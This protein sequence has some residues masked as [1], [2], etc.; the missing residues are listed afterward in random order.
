MRPGV[1]RF[2]VPRLPTV[3]T[4]EA[5]DEP[6]VRFRAPGFDLPVQATG[7]K[8]EGLDHRPAFLFAMI[9]L[10]AFSRLSRPRLNDG[11]AAHTGDLIAAIDINGM[12]RN[13]AQA[14]SRRYS[15]SVVRNHVVTGVNQMRFPHHQD[16]SHA[17]AFTLDFTEPS[18]RKIRTAPR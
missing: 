9:A 8:L 7:C 3:Q 12:V 4:G 18:G 10:A 2:H 14:A 16:P 1:A 11:L 15:L 5:T 6:Q 17:A 13:H